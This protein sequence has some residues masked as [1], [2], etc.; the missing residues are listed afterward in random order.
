MRYSEDKNPRND[1]GWTPLHFAA[2]EGYLNICEFIMNLLEDKN[3]GNNDGW[4]PLHLAA[5]NLNGRVCKFIASQLED[6]NPENNGKT[7]LQLWN[8]AYKSAGRQLFN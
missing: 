4:T 2:Q 3:P 1:K 7:P 8:L 5:S 6:K